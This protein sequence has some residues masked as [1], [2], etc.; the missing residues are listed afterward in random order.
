MHIG[1]R[2]R[3]EPEPAPVPAGPEM[4]AEAL[5]VAARAE[6]E[7]ILATA[8]AEAE[9]LRT[10]A[11]AQIEGVRKM[12]MQDTNAVIAEM[13]SRARAE[14]ASIREQARLDGLARAQDD[15]VTEVDARRLGAGPHGLLPRVGV[16]GAAAPGGGADG[17]AGDQQC[18][19]GEDEP[20]GLDPG[21]GQIR[22]LRGGVT[23]RGGAVG[24]GQRR[25]GERG[26]GAAER[27]GADRQRDDDGATDAAGG[28]TFVHEGAN[29]R[30]SGVACGTPQDRWRPAGLARRWERVA[31]ARQD[32]ALWAKDLLPR[33]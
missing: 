31:R 19:A 20:A 24:I 6:A 13:M 5:L 33:G 26:P 4:E 15:S 17:D 29:I 11:A 22:L 28:G 1:S 9:Q 14:A 12:V 21:G 2:R 10:Q 18:R 16:P 25:L 8:R 32:P 7:Q 3:A 27:T 30:R 23:V